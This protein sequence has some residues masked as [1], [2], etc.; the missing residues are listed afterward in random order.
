VPAGWH[1]EAEWLRWWYNMMAENGRPW[2]N[3]GLFRPNKT[4]A[5]ILAWV[6]I[7]LGT[8]L[9]IVFLGMGADLG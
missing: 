2:W 3:R 9:A 1:R 6:F 7:L 8:A 4:Q 5:A